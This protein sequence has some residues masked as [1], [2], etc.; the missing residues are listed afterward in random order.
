MQELYLMFVLS[1]L[2]SIT[3][4]LAINNVVSSRQYKRKNCLNT[5]KKGGIK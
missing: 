1:I 5:N 2:L 3:L 4:L